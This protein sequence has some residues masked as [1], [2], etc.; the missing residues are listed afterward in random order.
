M[1][2]EAEEAVLNGSRWRWMLL[3]LVPGLLSDVMFLGSVVMNGAHSDVVA[4][5]GTGLLYLAAL[6]PFVIPLYLIELGRRYVRAIHGGYQS[7]TPFVVMYAAANFVL[8]LAGLFLVL[9]N[10]KWT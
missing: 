10:I 6:S 7:P 1:S 8:W 9:A 5:L 4:A 2:I 3:A